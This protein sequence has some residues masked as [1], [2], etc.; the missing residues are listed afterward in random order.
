[1]KYDER[2]ALEELQSGY[3]KA[4]ELLKDEDKIERLLQ[5]LE[6][7]MKAIPKVGGVLASVPIFAS[8]IRNYI[9]REYTDIPVGTIIAIVS[10]VI[11]L[12]NPFD[13]IPDIVPG[14]G[15]L[16]DAAIIAVCL[17]LVDS[18]IKEYVR[19]RDANNKTLIIEQ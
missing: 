12:V 11:Y 15:L 9:K 1:M 7:K 16:D 2:K 5:R 19:W 18:D 14:F 13:I 8:L 3:G 4:E 6:N 10:A 17:K